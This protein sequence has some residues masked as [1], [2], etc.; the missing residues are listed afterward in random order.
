MGVKIYIIQEKYID[1]LRESDE[2]VLKINQKKDLYWNSFKQGNFDY[3]SPL[4]SP[5]EKHKLMKRRLDFI[6]IR[7]VN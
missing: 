3:F 1:Y 5:K 6:K 4:G 2:K 7:M